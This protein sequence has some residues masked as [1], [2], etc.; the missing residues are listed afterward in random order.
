M[1][2]AMQ[3]E[4]G[5]PALFVLP[6]SMCGERLARCA[7]SPGPATVRWK[8]LA[9]RGRVRVRRAVSV[10]VDTVRRRRSAV[11]RVCAT[12]I[13][14]R[15]ATETGS[16][17]GVSRLRSS[18]VLTLASPWHPRADSPSQMPFGHESSR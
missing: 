11:G 14:W 16:A 15:V 9:L 10:R 3:Q 6:S 4:N 13:N 8:R 17:Q 2:K 7:S 1:E 18:G 12:R 5:G